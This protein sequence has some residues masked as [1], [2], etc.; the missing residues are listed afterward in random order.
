MT[1][2]CLW[3]R[4]NAE[5]QDQLVVSGLSHTLCPAMFVSNLFHAGK[6]VAV[7]NSWSG[8]ALFVARGNAGRRPLG[9]R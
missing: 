7:N 1:P 6:S 3:G 8:A 5:I 9:L 4:M 2:R